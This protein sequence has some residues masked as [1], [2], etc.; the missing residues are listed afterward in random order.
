M[1]QIQSWA[2]RIQARDWIKVGG[3][4][5]TAICLL[6]LLVFPIIG[7]QVYFR[8][9]D[10]S[11][12]HWASDFQGRFTDVFS[13]NPDANSWGNMPGMGYYR[14]TLYII[15]LWLV[16]TFGPRP[17]ILMAFAGAAM[18]LTLLL[19]LLIIR[20]GFSSF[21]SNI[22]LILVGLLYNGLL[23]Q[24]FR[25]LVPFSYFLEML[26]I[27]ALL[28]ALSKKI[29]IKQR[30]ILLRW[31]RQNSIII[32]QAAT[33]IFQSDGYFSPEDGNIPNST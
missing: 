16:K 10:A 13:K 22:A 32:Q 20:R 19:Y 30:I 5:F 24:A 21:T 25:L 15:A 29:R 2:A 26:A 6:S 31:H 1:Y 33:D 8:H 27:G 9:D 3:R 23:Y 28:I 14:P 12:I 11:F 17:D 4:A 18:A 7:S